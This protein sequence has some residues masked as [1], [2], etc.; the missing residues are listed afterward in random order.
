MIVIV[1]GMSKSGTSLVSKTLHDSGIDMRPKKIGSYQEKCTYEDQEAVQIL[2]RMMGNNILQSMYLPTELNM[3]NKIARSIKKLVSSRRGSWGIKQPWMTLCYHLWKPYLPPH[4]VVGVKRTPE[5]LLSFWTKRNKMV[6][7]KEVL[8]VQ[9]YYNKIIDDL[10]IP[11]VLFEDFIVH[12]PVVLELILK[13]KLKD[14][15]DNRNHLVKKNRS[16]K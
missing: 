12:G 1:L 2:K 13:T 4:I 3:N 11:V 10:K 16:E 8:H 15:R 6:N 5:G 14:V 7:E 9:S